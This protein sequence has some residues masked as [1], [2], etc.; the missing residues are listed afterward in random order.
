[1]GPFKEAFDKANIPYVTFRQGEITRARLEQLMAENSVKI[2]TMHS[3]K[4]LAW[5][6][7]AVAG[8]W[9][10]KPEEYRLN[11]VAATRARKLLIMYK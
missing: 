8:C 11:Y 1:M 10:G 3:S 2:L 9:W 7:V 6:N 5:D 4:G